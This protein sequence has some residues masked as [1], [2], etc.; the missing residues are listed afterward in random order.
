MCGRYTLHVQKQKLAKAI[1]LALPDAYEPDYNIGPGREVLSIANRARQT[2]SAAMMQWGLRTPQN[3]HINAR[4]E[5]ADTSPRFRDSW[6]AHRCLLPANGYYEWYQDGI[7]KQP[8]YIYPEQGELYYFAGLWFPAPK[9]APFPSVVVLTTAAHDSLRDIHERM[10]VILPNN[11]SADWLDGALDKRDTLA[12]SDKVSLQKHPVSRRVNSVHNKDS[13]LI[14][15]TSAQS[16]D[17]M[18]LF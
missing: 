16:D 7:T 1:A 13:Q 4:I 9:D 5:T 17:Q 6:H 18:M 10:P 12:L 8:Y 15:A 2:P 11:S 3:F 14:E